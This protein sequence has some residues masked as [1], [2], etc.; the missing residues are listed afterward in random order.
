M[1]NQAANWKARRFVSFSSGEK[2][3]EKTPSLTALRRKKERKK[4]RK[5]G[6]K[7]E[8]KKE[9]KKE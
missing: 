7:E 9:R 3:E 1:T 5:K 8:R 6:R 4:E 2:E